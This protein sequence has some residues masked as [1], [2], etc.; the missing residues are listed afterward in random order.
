[1]RTLPEHDPALLL[2]ALYQPDYAALKSRAKRAVAVDPESASAWALLALAHGAHGELSTAEDALSEAAAL[3]VDGPSDANYYLG[4]AAYICERDSDAIRHFRRPVPGQFQ[5][6][7]AGRA[8]A[9]ARAPGP[10]AGGARGGGAGDRARPRRPDALVGARRDRLH[11][12]AAGR[13]RPRERLRRGGRAARRRPRR[14]LLHDRR[15]GARRGD[16]PRGRPPGACAR[17]GA[18]DARQARRG[19][20]R[21]AAGRARLRGARARAHRQ[22]HREPP[23]RRR[24]GREAPARRPAQHGPQRAGALPAGGGRLH[25]RRRDR[26][27]RLPVPAPTPPTRA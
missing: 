10:P 21:D 24:A 23:A 13:P 14:E 18:A 27:G 7:R 16:L 15:P 5:A 20:P 12:R 25:R 8:R 1:M 9:R 6:A 26:R 19:P 4:F 22:R 11:A 17:A 2:D 3:V